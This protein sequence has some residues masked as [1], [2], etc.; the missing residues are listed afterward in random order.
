MLTKK[1]AN[2]SANIKNLLEYN[3]LTL[4]VLQQMDFIF[5]IHQKVQIKIDL[6]EEQ[7]HIEEM[8]LMVLMKLVY[9]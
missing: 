3:N 1:Y 6:F 5:L 2:H 4:I 9:D 8:R 7:L